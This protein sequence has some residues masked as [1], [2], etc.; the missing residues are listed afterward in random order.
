MTA[1][2]MQLHPGEYHALLALLGLPEAW[3]DIASYER[4][5]ELLASGPRAPAR[6][7]GGM[8]AVELIAESVQT[9]GAP[10]PDLDLPDGFNDTLGQD[11][12]GR[13]LAR[14]AAE[15]WPQTYELLAGPTRRSY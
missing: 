12:A 9:Y 10:L 14:A 15:R 2:P 4:S 13:K 6:L 5:L 11:G 8:D 3:Q 1:T 7:Q